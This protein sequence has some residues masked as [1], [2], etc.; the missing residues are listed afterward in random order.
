MLKGQQGLGQRRSL[1][2]DA[3]GRRFNPAPATENWPVT[4]GNAG[5][6]P[7]R[8]LSHSGLCRAFVTQKPRWS[9]S[10][11]RPDG[12]RVTTRSIASEPRRDR[13]G[14]DVSGRW[15]R[16]G[17]S[18]RGIRCRSSRWLSLSSNLF[19]CLVRAV[20]AM[21]DPHTDSPAASGAE[22]SAGS[23]YR[24]R[25][26][27]ALVCGRQSYS[28]RGVREPGEIPGLTRSGEGDGARQNAT[29]AMLWEGA[30]HRLIPSPKTCWHW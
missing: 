13:N 21:A 24:S 27:E 2:P 16:G 14:A 20:P 23:P 8:H 6:G 10:E 22:V 5:H 11:A 15:R 3:R 12:A 1:A 28:T 4:C 7:T 18:P 19:H 29:G 25:E 9:R 30:S 26:W 17:L